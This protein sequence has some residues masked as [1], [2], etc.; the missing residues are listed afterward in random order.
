MKAHKM[1]SRPRE[2]MFVGEM[3]RR[4]VDND[5]RWPWPARLSFMVAA[6]VACWAIPLVILYLA[7]F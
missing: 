2:D 1:I 6:A 4:G 5:G 3:V 7:A